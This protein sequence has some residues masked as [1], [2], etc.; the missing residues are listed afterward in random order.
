MERNVSS[1]NFA[2]YFKNA[3]IKPKLFDLFLFQRAPG[4]WKYISEGENQ[5]K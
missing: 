4:K 1:A 2:M 5:K 3:E